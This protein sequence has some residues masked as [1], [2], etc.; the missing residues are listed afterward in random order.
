MSEPDE[1]I[2]FRLA[3]GEVRTSELVEVLTTQLGRIPAVA[4]AAV[5]NPGAFL[6]AAVRSGAETARGLADFSV[7]DVLA[8]GWR[9]HH[10]FKEYTTSKY[11]PGTE[12]LVPIKTH[13]LTVTSKPYLE[14]FVDQRPQ[15]TIDFELK[16]DL[17]VDAGVLV[18]R[19][20]R[21][22]RIEAGKGKVTTT[23]KCEGVTVA[24]GATRPFRWTGAV[25]LGEGIPIQ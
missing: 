15:G 8:A 12:S 9:T 20:K 17:A 24:E 3:P 23:L 21:L 18:I 10:R 7:A 11:P 14:V 6:S 19:D 2:R 1:M 4:A 25:S 13:K 16:V 22:I 5:A